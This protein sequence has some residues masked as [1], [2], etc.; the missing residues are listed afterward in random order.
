MRLFTRLTDAFRRRSRI[1]KPLL[2]FISYTSSPRPAWVV[3]STNWSHHIVS[4]Q[5]AVTS[6]GN[7]VVPW[8]NTCP[9]ADANT[10]PR[11]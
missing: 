3:L 9:H 7:V 8:Q 4:C 5:W 1:T 11:I 6:R 10:R 2:H